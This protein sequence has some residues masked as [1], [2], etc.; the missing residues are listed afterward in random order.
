[1]YSTF[2]FA[3]SGS[4]KKLINASAPALFGAPLGIVI[5]STHL[6]EPSCGIAYFKLEFPLI[7]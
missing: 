3:F 7:E 2:I 1:M 5:E 6:L 4:H